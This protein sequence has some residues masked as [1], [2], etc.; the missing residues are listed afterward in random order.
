MS[1][2][3]VVAG[4][5]A[6]VVVGVTALAICVSAEDSVDATANPSVKPTLRSTI[7]QAS[8]STSQW[9]WKKQAEAADSLVSV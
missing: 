4:V 8:S 6:A 1:R 5:A 3:L 9:M 7:V 2:I